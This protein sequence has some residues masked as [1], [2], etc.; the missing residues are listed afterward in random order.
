MTP[1]LGSQPVSEE[2]VRERPHCWHWTERGAI[3]AGSNTS[4]QVRC[5]WCNTEA[6]AVTQ[7]SYEPAEGHGHFGREER[8]PGEVD[9]A[10]L[11][12]QLE[13][14]REHAEDCHKHRYNLLVEVI[15]IANTQAATI[16]GLRERLARQ[17]AVIEAARWVVN[18]WL[19]MCYDHPD[20]RGWSFAE[21]VE[22]LGA[23]LPPQAQR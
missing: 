19:D 17:E 23:A 3:T 20:R 13:E 8:K 15:E 5:C 11:R 4:A 10:A 12:D 1:D 14:I 16:E 21:T 18:H 9:V 6:V 2:H 22:A 7:P